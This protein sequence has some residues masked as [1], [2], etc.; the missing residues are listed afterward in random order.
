MIKLENVGGTFPNGTHALHGVN[1]DLD[2]VWLGPKSYVKVRE[3]DADMEPVV[4]WINEDTRMAGYNSML[5]THKDSGIKTIA[6]AEGR[7]FRLQRP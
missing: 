3:Q 6:D 1:L 2:I 5:I 4:K 7:T